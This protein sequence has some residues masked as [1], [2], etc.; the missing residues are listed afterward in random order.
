MISF[1]TIIAIA[2]IRRKLVSSCFKILP[3]LLAENKQENKLILFDINSQYGFL[4]LS[5]FQLISAIANFIQSVISSHK[6]HSFMADFFKCCHD[7]FLPNST[8]FK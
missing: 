7:L 6:Y 1:C 5:K 4:S 3:L 2:D 8:S